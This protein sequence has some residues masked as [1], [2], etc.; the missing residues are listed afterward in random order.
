MRKKTV[1]ESIFYCMECK[2]CWEKVLEFS[3][4]K[5]VIR[6]YHYYDYPSY[7]KKKK[8]CPDCERA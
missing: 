7:G 8:I 6:V 1:D 3:G 4:K 5:R 2:S